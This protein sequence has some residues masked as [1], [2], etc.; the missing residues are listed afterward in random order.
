M[1]GERAAEQVVEAAD[2]R[3]P[4]WARWQPEAIVVTVLEELEEQE[5]E[6]SRQEEAQVVG[7]RVH[8]GL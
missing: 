2:D 8:G 4:P 3:Q 5:R 6:E 1:V 7:E